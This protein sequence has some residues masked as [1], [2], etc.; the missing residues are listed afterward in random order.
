L[1]LRDDPVVVALRDTPVDDEPFTQGGDVEL[2]HV[3]DASPP[4]GPCHS[5]RLRELE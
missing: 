2:A 1:D 4:N 3:S 5:A